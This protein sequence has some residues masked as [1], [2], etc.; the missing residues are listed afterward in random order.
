MQTIAVS[1]TETSIKA[2]ARSGYDRCRRHQLNPQYPGNR[3]I[4]LA[5]S[6]LR[7]RNEGITNLK[8][9]QQPANL[10]G[11]A[12]AHDFCKCAHS[13]EPECRAKAALPCTSQVHRDTRRPAMQP[14]AARA[15]SPNQSVCSVLRFRCIA[16]FPRAVP[17]HAQYAGTNPG[18]FRRHVE[19]EGR[20]INEVH[21]SKPRAQNREWLRAVCP[22][23]HARSNRLA[24]R[25]PFRQCGHSCYFAPCCDDGLPDKI[26]GQLSRT[27]WQRGA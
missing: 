23:S 7:A 21:V 3:K 11:D 12:D 25:P 10:A 9:K 13:S 17:A 22:W 15:L 26:P 6:C 1:E 20:S 5:W 14:Q 18:L 2:R 8:K 27:R 19:H 24:G 16:R 4:R